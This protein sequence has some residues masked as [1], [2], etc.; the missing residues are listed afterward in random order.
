MFH[1]PS[2]LNKQRSPIHQKLKQ[3]DRLSISITSDRPS[4]KTKP[5]SD[6]LSIPTNS[7]R[8]SNLQQ[9]A[10]A[11]LKNQPNSDRP[12]ISSMIKM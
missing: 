12:V 8:L 7:D 2:T 5:I 11:P 3:G 9:P 6:R 1:R 4:K 10:I